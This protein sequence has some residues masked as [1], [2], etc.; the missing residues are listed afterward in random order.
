MKLIYKRNN[1]HIKQLV[2]LYRFFIFL[3]LRTNTKLFMIWTVWPQLSY[4]SLSFHIIINKLHQASSLFNFSFMRLFLS[5]N[6]AK[7]AALLAV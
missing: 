4:I 1:L 5:H 7:R 6:P 2:A 3:C